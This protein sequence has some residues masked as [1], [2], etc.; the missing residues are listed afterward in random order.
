MRGQ[1]PVPGAVALAFIPG[2]PFVDRVQRPEADFGGAPDRARPTSAVHQHDM[3]SKDWRRLLF[4][5]EL[6]NQ[7]GGSPLGPGSREFRQFGR[8]LGAGAKRHHV[9][10]VVLQTG[11]FAKAAPEFVREG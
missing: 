11:S 3:A 6:T 1:P 5:A 8:H 10:V 7:S 2:K 4:G 9:V